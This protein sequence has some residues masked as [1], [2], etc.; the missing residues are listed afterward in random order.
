LDE[1]VF[2]GSDSP[3]EPRSWRTI[4]TK[5]SVVAKP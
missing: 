1:L 5:V 2:A 3:K 4:S